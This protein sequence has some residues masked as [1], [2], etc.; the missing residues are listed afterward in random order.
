MHEIFDM[1]KLRPVLTKHMTK[2][3][4]QGFVSGATS[5][6]KSIAGMIEDGRNFDEI[7]NFVKAEINKCD[8]KE[9]NE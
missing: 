9:K 2:M 5:A 4:Q 7:A 3:Y 8:K 1:E 6:Y